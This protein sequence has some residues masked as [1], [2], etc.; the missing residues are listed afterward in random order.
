MDGNKP[1]IR[2]I[3]ADAIGYTDRF[4]RQVIYC[5]PKNDAVILKTDGGITI[6]T[7]FAVRI[8]SST[9]D[10]DHIQLVG[11][12]IYPYMS[13]KGCRVYKKHLG[14]RSTPLVHALDY[15][16]LGNLL[17]RRA[18]SSYIDYT[19]EEPKRRYRYGS[20]TILFN[21]FEIAFIRREWKKILIERKFKKME[22]KNGE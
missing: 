19:L 5:S 16:H 1:I 11:N 8:V 18:Y 13:L 2:K 17:I 12:Y 7:D 14:F 21:K 6:A 22:D 20:P 9:E 15:D 10:A 4:G 3:G